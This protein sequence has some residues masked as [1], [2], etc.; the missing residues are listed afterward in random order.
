MYISLLILSAF[1][2]H[3]LG[4]IPLWKNRT[5][6][7]G[8]YNGVS[9]YSRKCTGDK[10]HNG[11]REEKTERRISAVNRRFKKRLGA[12]HAGTSWIKIGG[13]GACRESDLGFRLKAPL[14][15]GAVSYVKDRKRINGYLG[16]IIYGDRSCCLMHQAS[17]ASESA[18]TYTRGSA[19]CI[20]VE[21]L[22][23][24]N[25]FV[26]SKAIITI[27]STFTETTAAII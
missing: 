12:K 3:Q 26:I 10:E 13:D 1:G 11:R 24:G 17:W 20:G 16:G 19:V 18:I 6:S 21:T 5:T 14:E 23:M 22:L 7:L 25:S 2:D 15:Y 4:R 8:F 27:D 9:P